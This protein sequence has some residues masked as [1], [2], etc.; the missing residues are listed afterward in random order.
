[1]KITIICTSKYHP[2]NTYL[3]EWMV[4]NSEAHEIEIVRDK[5]LARGGDILFLISCGQK[6]EKHERDF[7][8]KTLVIHASDLPNGKGWNP[9]IWQIIEGK[10]TIT[11]T[12]LEAADNID[13]GDIWSKI[14]C[15]ISKD[16]LWDEINAAIFEAEMLLMDFAIENGN[17]ISPES[18]DNLTGDG[19]Y[20]RLRNPGDSQLDPNKS[21]AEQFNL[22]RVCDPSRFPAFFELHGCKYKLILEKI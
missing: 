12:L 7:Y 2:V 11:V 17:N 8:K 14:S 5:S 22:I 18:Q 21:I 19:V 1:M 9:H 13:S 3:H 20:Y 15:P 16:A 10:S 4:R 6:V